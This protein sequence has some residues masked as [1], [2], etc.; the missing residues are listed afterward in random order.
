MYMLQGMLQ[1]MDDLRNMHMEVLPQE[2]QQAAADHVQ[3]PAQAAGAAQPPGRDATQPQAPQAGSADTASAGVQTAAAEAGAGPSASQQP[4]PPSPHHRQPAAWQQQ[5]SSG[6]S[7]GGSGSH[8]T[9]RGNSVQAPGVGPA[10]PAPPAGDTQQGQ[11]P[12]TS[13]GGHA[14]PFTGRA[15]RLD[16]GDMS[17]AGAAAELE[18]GDEA[19]SVRR[20]LRQRLPARWAGASSGPE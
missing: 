5:L 4:R 1:D 19:T 13:S 15:F 14:V 3:P 16:G 20:T 17:G 7:F 12:A 11:Y 10:G 9:A 8:L 2:Q 18:G 6:I